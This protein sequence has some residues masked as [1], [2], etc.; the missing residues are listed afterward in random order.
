MARIGRFLLDTNIVI[1]LF[2]GETSIQQRLAEASE[3]F[4]PCIVLGEL[5]YGARKST[6]VTENLAR[7]DEFVGSS[8][9]LPCDTVTAQQYGDIKNMPL[10]GGSADKLGNRY[11]LW[12]T[13]WQLVRMLDGKGDS[14]R[15]EDPGVTKAEFVISYGGR[16]ELHQAKR[17]HPDG[18]WSLASLSASDMRLLQ[19]IH[20]QLTG[21]DDRF[22]F[23]SSSDA[24]ELADLAERS[25]QAESLQEFEE[26]FLAAK[27]TRNLF[28]RLQKY[29]NNANVATAFDILKRVEVRAMDEQGIE[30]NVTWGLRALFLSNPISVCN[31]LRALAEHSVHKTL[32]RGDLLNHL[33]SRSYQLRRLRKP[34]AASVLVDEVTEQYLAG[35]RKKLIRKT[36]LPR[37][38]TQVLLSR[39]AEHVGG[40]DVVLTGT[41]GAGKTGCVIEFVEALRSRGIPVLAFRLDRRAPVSSTRDFS[42]QFG[43]EESP[44][45]VLAAAAEAREAVLVVDQLDAVSTTSGRRADF[46]DA[47]EGM[48]AE[49]RGLRERVKL[50]V[51][52]VCRAFDWENDHRLRPMVS[53]NHAQIEVAEFSLDEVRTVL[54]AE[55]FSVEPDCLMAR[56]S[57]PRR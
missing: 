23:V 24:R 55:R 27:E 44:A 17:S 32:T 38:A 42:Q 30:E 13:V 45:L 43:L 46:C 33:V 51:V 15:I 40:G 4:V 22:V 7:I 14:I 10:P 57:A 3:V 28:E 19:A 21:N 47:V 12:W 16:R 2:A 53:K 50:H 56:G 26:K 35:V 37:E 18:K 11:E 41:A 29:W 39:M 54:A 34:E 52:V 6:R 48:L 5:Y 9:V 49:A 31:E 20:A 8:T 1:A 25:Q 36:L